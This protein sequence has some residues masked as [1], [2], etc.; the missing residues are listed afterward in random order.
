MS[1]LSAIN[2]YFDNLVEPSFQRDEHGRELF[3]PMG[4]GSRGRIVP[5]ASTSMRMR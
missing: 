1:I 3:F 4:F 2:R 5:D